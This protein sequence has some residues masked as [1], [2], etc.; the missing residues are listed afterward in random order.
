MFVK[1]KPGIR[2]VD[3]EGFRILEEEGADVHPSPFWSK[4]VADGDVFV[5]DPVAPA[6]PETKNKPAPAAKD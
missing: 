3:P 5:A 2:V 1:P 6:E 4:R